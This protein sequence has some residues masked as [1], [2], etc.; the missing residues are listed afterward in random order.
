MEKNTNYSLTIGFP[1]LLTLVFI[2]LK[3]CHVITWPWLWVLAPMWIGLGLAAVIFI[4]ALLIK[5][6]HE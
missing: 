5:V 3:L 6:F 2:V 4:I 1:E